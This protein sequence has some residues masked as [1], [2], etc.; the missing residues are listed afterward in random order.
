MPNGINGI[1]SISPSI[2]DYLLGR[3]LILSDTITNNS[4]SGLAVGLGYPA[5]IATYP[6]SVQASNDI[7]V[8]GEL[9]RDLNLINNPYGTSS[10]TMVDINTNNIQNIGNLPLG[11]PQ[12][13]YPALVGSTV[14]DSEFS[15]AA[16]DAREQM[17]FNRYQPNEGDQELVS[18][19]NNSFNYSDSNGGY[20]DRNGN[21]N[22]GGPSTTPLDV[23][24]SVLNGG[25]IGIGGDTNFDVRS[26]LAGRVLGAT[27]IINDTPLGIIG[28]QQLLIALGNK[29][30]FNAQ[31]ELLGQLNLN[32]LSLA[33]GNDIIVPD[34]S[35]TVGSDGLRRSIDI[36][37]NILG[38]ENPLNNGDLAL[39]VPGSSIF[40]KEN[41]VD[42]KTRIENQLR[43]TG[44]GQ[45]NNLFANLN[46][47]KYRLGITDGRRRENGIA[48]NMYIFY[49]GNGGMINMLDNLPVITEEGD[50]VG[51]IANG[52]NSPISPSNHS[53]GKFTRDAGF[54]SIHDVKI[55]EE[56]F[57]WA[58]NSSS[59][60]EEEYLPTL[61]EE[62]SV[63][64]I[65]DSS[66]Y[67]A[68]NFDKKTILGKTKDLFKNN[69]MTVMVSRR[70]LELNNV[71]EIDNAV[72]VG[73][74]SYISRGSGVKS[75]KALNG[76][77]NDANEVFCRSWTSIYKYNQVK[78]LQKSEG[79]GTQFGLR[80]RNTVSSSVLDD[81]GF[82]R[83]T[84]YIGDDIAKPSNM[85]RFMFSIENLAWHGQMDKLPASEQGTGDP[86]TGTKGRIMWF[87]P[88]D[89]KFSEDSSLNW[90]TH[91]FIGRGEPVYT[92]NNTERGGNLSFKV[93]MDHPSYMNDM[94]GYYDN[95]L[96][97]SIAAGCADFELEKFKNITKN[98]ADAI[99]VANA[100]QP[101]YINDTPEKE[102]EPFTI[103]FPNDVY[104]FRGDT[105]DYENG[106]GVG[107][108]KIK[109]DNVTPG[110][111]ISYD[112]RTDYGLNVP[113]LDSNF[114]PNLK[115]K[116]LK[117]CPS[118]K[119]NLDGYA[120][121]D[122]KVNTNNFLA[123]NR[124]KNVKKKILEEIFNNNDIIGD[125]R[126][127]YEKGNGETGNKADKGVTPVD[128][129]SKKEARKV[130]VSFKSDPTIKQQLIEAETKR[131]E[132]KKRADLNEK[133][134][135]RFFNEAMYFEKLRQ[136]DKITYDSIGEKI[137]FFHPA[138]HSITPEGFNSRLT[139]LQQ[140]TRQGPTLNS[141]RPD[142]LAFGMAPVCILRIGDFYHTKIIIEN[143]SI[144]YDTSNGVQWDLNP[145]GVGVQPMIANV[146]MSFKFIG[147][148]S[149]DG[150]INKL[151]NAVSFNFFANT[152]VYD[153]RADYIKINSDPS[154][155]AE[156]VNDNIKFSDLVDDSKKEG[157]N[158]NGDVFKDQVSQ[159][160]NENS[161]EEAKAITSGDV[162]PRILG[163]SSANLCEWVDG[164]FSLSVNLKSEGFY[165]ATTYGD[166]YVF[167]SFIDEDGS[168]GKAYFSKGV[169]FTLTDSNGGIIIEEVVKDIA[170][171]PDSS[172]ITYFDQALGGV[173]YN[174]GTE[175]DDKGKRFT[176]S[177]NTSSIYNLTV[178]YNGMRI[179]TVPIKIGCINSTFY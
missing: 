18:L 53:L 5:S 128:S 141:D 25:G 112:D 1:N 73:N 157:L 46:N 145:E 39:F 64:Q 151:Q 127:G 146:T 113:V 60:S 135:S 94:R 37:L 89:L 104:T 23:I 96:F 161:K 137:K 109:D 57:T 167:N 78:N 84:P 103:Y 138:F 49:D 36:G 47:N 41:P 122:G 7:V 177:L 101:I 16:N 65:S 6:E 95:D 152:E 123:D 38:I 20:L 66:K 156:Y 62:G 124:A 168:K 81:N 88:Y 43:N 71:N 59:V 70:G 117:Q 83:V 29:V 67:S 154:K 179:Q 114:W 108:G 162:T 158:T 26:S 91:N 149:L 34:Y 52:P 19:N 24:G 118:C 44:K 99:E 120:S 69:N 105:I 22:V 2:R 92:Y 153:P 98:E 55:G 85:K 171:K 31:R 139:F 116:L 63:I 143:I 100:N 115:E 131:V 11:T 129:K 4:L 58:H 42:T 74:S 176:A 165:S 150:P 14:I 148:S 125:D 178:M 48:P 9:Y 119:I 106:D 40:Y 87:P 142:N 110:Q 86:K 169:K 21:L 164:K 35:I 134:K 77:V 97:A 173:G 126:F 155:N 90:D 15:Q 54:Q 50:F 144:D 32:P 163:F 33:N 13:E 80:N 82:V 147:G 12:T 45:L 76:S 111:T 93:L 30:A 61:N 121:V 175:Y 160:E 174:V 28:G 3:N 132:N 10:P 133:I 17:L 166:Q 8:D 159:A 102:P 140:C 75:G 136:D 72:K 27:G 79:L 107:L 172:G 68:I 130:V 51:V 170:T 56:G